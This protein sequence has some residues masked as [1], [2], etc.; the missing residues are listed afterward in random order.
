MS[1]PRIVLAVA[2]VVG[3]GLFVVG[4]RGETHHEASN[5]EA[6]PSS[7]EGTP[8]AEAAENPASESA[9]SHQTESSTENGE[10]VLRV[11]LEAPALVGGVVGLSLVLAG[12]VLWRRSKV[13]LFLAVGFCLLALLA[14]IGELIRQLD[15]SKVA[16]AAVAAA[17]ALS[18]VVGAAAGSVEARAPDT[19]ATT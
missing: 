14:D 16:L 11:N 8:S 19:H 18:H 5:P 7:A 13:L 6:S 3:A 9:D 4:T 17:V 10:K 1:W 15:R 12:L 2:L